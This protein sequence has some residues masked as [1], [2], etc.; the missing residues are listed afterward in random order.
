ESVFQG[1]RKTMRDLAQEEGKSIEF[2]ILG[3]D[4]EADRMVLQALKDPLM[5]I[6]CNAVTHGIESPDERTARGKSD[7]GHITLTLELLGNR[8]RIAVDDD[9]RGIDRRTIAAAAVRHGVLTQA[10]ADEATADELTRLVFRPGF[11][12]AESV[13]D[14][15]GRGMGLSVV[16]ETV[17]R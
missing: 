13:T 15:S 1:F 8:L 5:H 12:T 11:S 14:L 9:G 16:Q 6:L 7:V 17:S 2:R 4:V 3:F 10:D